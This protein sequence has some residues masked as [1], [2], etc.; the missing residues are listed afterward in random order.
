LQKDWDPLD[1]LSAINAVQNA[2]MKGEI[3]TG[4]LY[5]DPETN[6]LHN[7]LNTSEHPLNK[8]TKNDLCPGSDILQKINSSLR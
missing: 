8:L 4:L 6:D 3:L 5:L 2:K 1:R 7:L